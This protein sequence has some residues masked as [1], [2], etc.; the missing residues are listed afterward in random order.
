MSH[1]M[2]Q[3]NSPGRFVFGIGRLHRIVTPEKRRRLL[4]EALDSGFRSFDVAPSYGNG[5]DELELGRALNGRRAACEVNTKFGIPIRIYNSSA[6]FSFP[7]WRAIDLMVGSSRRAYRRR[8][9]STD[10]ME[11]SLDASLRRLRTDH[12]DTLFLHEPIHTVDAE[13]L[14]S[15]HACADRMKRDGRI[16]S[17][18]VAGPAQSLRALQSLAQFDVVQTDPDSLGEL[19]GLEWTQATI[20]YG[21]YRAFSKAPAPGLFPTFVKELLNHNDATRVIL[22]STSIETTRRLGEMSRTLGVRL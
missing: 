13:I 18:G 7:L 11:S 6:R 2:T 22:S 15:L 16:R 3:K 14:Q 1:D 8:D 17:F 19:A 10:C 5:I 21:T 20:V 12:I 4:E 9:F